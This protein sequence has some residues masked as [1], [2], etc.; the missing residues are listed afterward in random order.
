M[1]TKA[2]PAPYAPGQDPASIEANRAYQDALK[3]LTDSLDQR[4]NRFFDPTY[5]AA[6]QGFL[7][8]GAPNFFESLGR[9]AKNVGQAQEAGI[10]EDQTIAQQRVELAGRGVE[11]QRQRAKDAMVRELLLDEDAKAPA[12]SSPSNADAGGLPSTQAA[13]VMGALA[14]A[15][16]QSASRSAQSAGINVAPPMPGITRQKFIALAI[17]G[18]KEPY[19]AV[20]EWENIQKGRREVKEGMIFDRQTGDMFP[21]NFETVETEIYGFPGTYRIPKTQAFRL[22]KLFLDNDEEGYKKLAKRIVEGFGQPPVAS[23]AGGAAPA[24]AA[25]PNAA[26]AAPSAAVPAAATG[27]AAAPVGVPREPVVP[28]AAA[29]GTP[30]AQAGAAKPPAQGIDLSRLNPNDPEAVQYIKKIFEGI[31]DPAER[32]RY[33]QALN[34][35]LAAQSGAAR[36]AAAAAQPAVA[37]PAAAAAVQPAADAGPRFGGIPSI[38]DLAE[39]KKRMETRVAKEEELSVAKEANLESQD[40]AARRLFGATTS[41]QKYLKQS[42]NFF[43]IFARPGVTAAIG[44]LVKEGIQT[45]GGTLNL[46]GFEDSMRKVMPGVKQADLDNVTKAGADLAE[47][48]LAYTRLYLEK[49]GAV[50][51]G[52]R[53]IVRAIPGTTSSSPEVLRTRMELLKSRAQYDIDVIDAFRQWQKNNPGRSYFEFES[54]SDLYRDIKRDFEKETEKIFGSIRAVPTRERKEDAAAGAGKEVSPARK[55]LDAILGN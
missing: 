46:A 22:S 47:I 13:P 5:L 14:Q 27:Q 55:R 51:E 43:G 20:K 31:K 7:E 11:L 21:A 19:E 37:Q 39:Q 33:L 32:E 49:Q 53:K 54:K 3:K 10:K 41:V 48:E 29:A 17:A 12:G 52:E 44:N 9:V 40:Q 25:T 1:S 45:P 18:G 4:K 26:K 36:P 28:A 38:Q 8:P 24:V 35:R 16:G 15:E 6:A 50:T 30:V 2:P 42:P 34:A 23:P